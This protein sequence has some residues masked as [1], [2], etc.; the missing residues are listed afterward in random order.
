MAGMPSSFIAMLTV[1][2]DMPQPSTKKLRRNLGRVG[3]Y[4][5]V[6]ILGAIG[7]PLVQ[8]AYAA[9]TS[10]VG[11]GPLVVVSQKWP[12]FSCS[13]ASYG[14]L[15]GGPDPMSTTYATGVKAVRSVGVPFRAGQLDLRLSAKD[16]K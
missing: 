15:P 5:I 3:I 13:P 14:V 2:T 1:M 10:A 4:V 7:E 16:P 8:R 12:D 9:L 6:F 11:D